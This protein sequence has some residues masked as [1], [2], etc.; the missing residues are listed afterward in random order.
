MLFHLVQLVNDSY[1]F[2]HRSRRYHVGL[3][4]FL[5]LSHDHMLHRQW[6]QN[7]GYYFGGHVQDEVEG[8]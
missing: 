2:Q 1:T 5:D 7:L 3:K 4:E 6:Q 8:I